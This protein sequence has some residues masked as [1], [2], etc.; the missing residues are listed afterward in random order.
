MGFPDT[1]ELFYNATFHDAIMML[2]IHDAIIDILCIQSGGRSGKVIQYLLSE[3]F[4][5]LGDQLVFHKVSCVLTTWGSLYK[6]IKK[7]I[8]L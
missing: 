1:W 3:L 5:V 6:V 8:N 2:I 7:I 4:I